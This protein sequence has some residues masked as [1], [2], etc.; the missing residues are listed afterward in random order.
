M[1]PLEVVTQTPRLAPR[2][3][4]SNKGSFGRV[5]VVAGSRGMSGAG[6]LC[7]TGAL[8]G[9]AGLVRLA[10][11]E[12]ILP[13]VASANPC[14]LTAPLPEDSQGRLSRQA[15]EEVLSLA[16]ANTV[17]ALGPGLGRSE[18]L[19]ALVLT[20]LSRVSLPL[21]LD[22]DGLN[23]L[24]GHTDQLRNRPGPLIMTPHPGE[25]AC[26]AGTDIPTVQAHRQELAGNFAAA[27]GVILVLKGQGTIV[28][29]GHGVYQNT[30]G[31]PG[32]ATG[33]TGDVLT[34][35]IAA[36]V[37][38]GLEPFG[39]AQ[40]GV[41]LHGLAGDLARDDLGEVSLIASDLLDYLPR[42]LRDF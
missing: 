35:L 5:L 25:F 13:I 32:M 23:A 12:G 8:R 11:P 24:Q 22:A 31:N 17:M 41:H 29:D 20:L 7:A 30:T 19:T 33:G 15:E 38:Q 42:A 28:T 40:L 34:G 21:V 39:A 14:Y 37:G 18:E 9:G 36:L 16:Q 6:V 2:A 3:A 10:V 26:L 1:P 27:H 4:D